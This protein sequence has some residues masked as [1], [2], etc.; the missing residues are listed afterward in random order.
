MLT[1]TP[2]SMPQAG[3]GFTRSIGTTVNALNN[4]TVNPSCVS[5]LNVALVLDLSGSITNDELQTY[6][7]ALTGFDRATPAN[8]VPYAPGSLLDSL[9]GTGSHMGFFTFSSASPASGSSNHPGL[10]PI[11]SSRRALRPCTAC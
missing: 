1:G 6:N 5:G 4:P 7:K 8:S 2:V 10:L 9:N 11:D 3:S